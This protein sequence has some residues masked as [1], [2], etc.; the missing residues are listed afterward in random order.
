MHKNL[1]KSILFIL[2]VYLSTD[3]AAQTTKED[4]NANFRLDPKKGL[5]FKTADDFFSLNFRF[6]MQNSVGITRKDKTEYDAE[7]KNLRLRFDGHIYSPKLSYK[8]QFSLSPDDLRHKEAG[9]GLNT[10]R[11]LVVQYQFNKKWSVVFGHTKLPG[12]RQQVNSSGELQL[13]GRS[14]NNSKFRLESDLGLH[15]NYNGVSED[16]FSYAVKSAISTGRGVQNKSHSDNSY[17]LTGKLELFPFG[18]FTNAGANYEGDLERELKPKLMLSGAFNFNNDVVWSQGLKGTSLFEAKDIRAVFLDVLF[19]HKGWAAMFAYLNRSVDNPMTQSETDPSLQAFVFA[20]H[21]TDYQL[22]YLFAN[23]YE[24][25]ARFSD[26][27][28]NDQLY[29]NHSPN[30]RQWSLGATKYIWKHKIKLQ[31]EVGFQQESYLLK[32]SKDSWYASAQIELGI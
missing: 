4:I 18:G 25:A 26:Q 8:I 24:I 14:I 32:P 3:V 27:R 1:L 13:T 19:K 6:R 5:G 9:E 30:T 15:I 21:G 10:I 29:Q 31:T 11:D 22:S 12:N 2:C 7:I 20:G 16:A 23:D 28:I 17:S